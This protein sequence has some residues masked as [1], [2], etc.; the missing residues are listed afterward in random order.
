MVKLDENRVG[1]TMYWKYLTF[2][3]LFLWSVLTNIQND[4]LTCIVNGKFAHELRIP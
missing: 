3:I 2:E 1:D 4:Y